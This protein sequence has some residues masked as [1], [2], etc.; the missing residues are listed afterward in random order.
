MSVFRRALPKRAECPPASASRA[1]FCWGRARQQASA[2][3][4]ESVEVVISV[5]EE[6]KPGNGTE[7][8]AGTKS[9]QIRVRAFPSLAVGKPRDKQLNQLIVSHGEIQGGYSFGDV[10]H[11]GCEPML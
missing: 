4:N 8:K 5:V 1:T 9:L 10:N 6:I 3:N 11:G 2:V 7:R